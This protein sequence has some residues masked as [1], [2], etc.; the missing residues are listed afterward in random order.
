MEL[1]LKG[2]V[3]E[4]VFDPTIAIPTLRN[5]RSDLRTCQDTLRKMHKKYWVA[6]DCS[7]GQPPIMTVRRNG[8]HYSLVNLTRYGTHTENCPFHYVPSKISTN[9]NV[10]RTRSNQFVFIDENTSNSFDNDTKS[11]MNTLKKLLLYLVDKSDV[12]KTYTDRTFSSNIK[13]ILDKG[14]NDVYVNGKGITK[15][16]SFGLINFLKVKEMFLSDVELEGHAEPYFIIDIVDSLESLETHLLAKKIAKGKDISSFKFFK[17]LSQ[18]SELNIENGPFLILSSISFVKA[19]SKRVVAPA[20]TYFQPIANK[21]SWL[22]VNNT[23]ERKAIEKIASSFE[24]YKKT[25]GLEFTCHRLLKP[26]HNDLGRCYP[27]FKFELGSHFAYFDIQLKSDSAKN[28]QKTMDYIVLSKSAGGAYCILDEN[29]TVKEIQ[30]VL[31][32]AINEVLKAIK[33]A[34]D[35]NPP[36]DKRMKCI[37]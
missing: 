19:K 5:A 16:L 30:N 34:T 13:A 2:N 3:S 12:N 32:K 7:D 10:K 20:L 35:N 31:F 37:S 4:K 21:R 14:T 18:I 6:C 1:R 26:I 11:S 24:W 27:L 9:T 36:F 29:Q 25:L 15:K 17:S 23:L 8:S 22:P 28:T 33:N